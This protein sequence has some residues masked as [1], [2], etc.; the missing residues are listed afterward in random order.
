MQKFIVYVF[1]FSALVSSFTGCLHRHAMNGDGTN[2]SLPSF[3]S[4]YYAIEPI[5]MDDKKNCPGDNKPDPDLA[6]LYN[7]GSKSTQYIIS[8][9][10]KITYLIAGSQ[11]KS[12]Q[13]NVTVDHLVYTPMELVLKVPRKDAGNFEAPVPIGLILGVSVR[14]KAKA[15]S[16]E[17]SVNISDIPGLGYSAN[18]NAASAYVEIDVIGIQNSTILKLPKF[19]GEVNASTLQTFVQN[20]ATINAEIDGDST[21][22]VPQII[23]VD[24][25]SLPEGVTLRDVV[26]AIRRWKAD[27]SEKEGPFTVQNLGG[28]AE[29]YSLPPLTTE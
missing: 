9:E 21:K 3:V 23:G 2:R 13:Y 6:A 10:G 27:R 8:K 25:K 19:V 5:A 15:I 22:I 12:G 20:L 24:M 1:M 14:I 18:I 7:V 28:K 29:V 26:D 17:G 16:K 4:G 11:A